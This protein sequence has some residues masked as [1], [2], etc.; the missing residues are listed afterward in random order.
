[1]STVEIAVPIDRTEQQ[2]IAAFVT[3]LDSLITLQQ[4]E[5]DKLKNIKQACLAK[6]FV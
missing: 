5:L 4:R 1:M 6:M 2:K 3:Q